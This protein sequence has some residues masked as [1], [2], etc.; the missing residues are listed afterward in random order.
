MSRFFFHIRDDAPVDDLVGT[1]LPTW[2]A[3][4]EHARQSVLDVAARS[5]RER[6]SFDLRHCI[7]VADDTG[8]ELLTIRLGDVVTVRGWPAEPHKD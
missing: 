4:E 3:V 6:G 8:N 7:I 2:D 5:I 1:E